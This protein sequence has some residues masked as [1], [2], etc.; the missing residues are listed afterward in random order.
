[1]ITSASVQVWQLELFFVSCLIFFCLN[2]LTGRLFL[3]D[4]GAYLLGLVVG[5]SI[6]FASNKTDVSP[7][8]LGMLIFYPTADF[9]FSI[10]RRLVTGG[11]AMSADNRHFH[12][13]V[14]ALLKRAGLSPQLANTLT[15]ISI[16][17]LWTGSAIALEIHI[18][19]DINWMLVYAL[20]W[21]SFI[22]LW[23]CMRSLS[24]RWIKEPTLS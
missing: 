19:D 11:S 15:G 8:F 4:G 18:G 22:T 6:I 10:V 1:M 12:N 23:W 17:I 20:S 3:G 21:L 16:A 7:W 14:F 13:L 2:V 5:T 9:F 24:A